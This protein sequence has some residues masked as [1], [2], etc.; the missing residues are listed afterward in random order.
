MVTHAREIVQVRKDLPSGSVILNRADRRN[1]LSLDM[2]QRIQEAFDDFA[3]EKRVRAVILTGTGHVFSSGSDLRELNEAR[4]PEH[5]APVEDEQLNALHALLETMLRFPKPIICAPNGWVVG[6]AMALMLASDLVVAS[7]KANFVLPEPRRGLVAGLTAPL[8][9]HRVGASRAAGML[10][11]CP[12]VTAAQAHDWGLVHYVVEDRLVWF[13][14]QE[15]AKEIAELAPE[16]M[17]LTK[18]LLNESICEELFMHLSIG[19]AN[20]ATARTT[21]TSREGVTA[22][23]ERRHPRWE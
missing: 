11:P 14:S 20:S 21:A 12:V 3:Q 9:V 1:A 18:K 22:F 5:L 10:F 17:Q 15:L 2:L 4:D 8:L 23:L 6:S 7:D 19:A 16:S 13:R